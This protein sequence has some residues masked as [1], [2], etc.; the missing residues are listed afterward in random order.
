MKKIISD[1]NP[2]KETVIVWLDFDAYSYFHLGVISKLSKL[3]KF[4]FIGIIT[5]KQ[6]MEFFEKQEFVKFKKLF[7]YP[8]C[9]IKKSTFNIDN[10]KKIEDDF[11]LNIWLNIFS[12]RSF[13]KFWTDFH[14]FTRE[15]ILVIIENSLLFFN[16]IL[17]K[18]KP[19]MILMQTPGENVSNVLLYELA[20]KMDIQTFMPM[21]IHYKDHIHISNNNKNSEISNKIKKLK[22]NF[23]EPL[24]MYDKE[25]IKNKNYSDVLKTISSFDSGIKSFSQKINHYIKRLS[26]NL[27]PIY[28]NVGKTKIR[29]IQ[30]RLHNSFEIKKREQFLDN[31]AEKT[32]ENEKFLYFPLQSEPEASILLNTPFYSNQ[33]NLIETIAKSI[34]INYVL[35]VKEHPLQ[36]IKLWR[37]IDDYKKIK[38]IPNVRFLHPS[39]NAQEV[40]EKSQGVIAISGATGFEALFYHKPVI[41]FGD[42]YYDELSMVTKI[43]TFD[44]LPYKIRN[45]L[46]NFEFNEKE[47]SILVKVLKEF[48]LPIPYYSILKDGVSLS[49]I[50]KNHNNFNLTNLEFEKFIK[51]WKEEFTLLAKTILIRSNEID[52]K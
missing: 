20:K 42:E 2:I 38:S 39:V 46:S 26:N 12:D 8:D 5:R 34:P 22:D 50:Q 44:E 19:K 41:L 3:G 49:S 30:N 28:L 18:E 7:Y 40:L 51:K 36:K 25:F 21:D 32:L 48:A 16:D 37:S 43:E 47:L 27:E 1:E 10:L 24:Q 29:L 6:D 13:N 31:Y 33:I 9:Y 35:Y 45:T 17:E 52:E 11:D 23:D 4:D 15:E 14:K